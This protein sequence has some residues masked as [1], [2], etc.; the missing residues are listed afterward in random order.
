M[1]AA[2]AVTPLTMPVEGLTLAIEV[3]LLDHVPP[4]APSVKVVEAPEQ[5]VAAPDTVPAAGAGFT[6][7]EVVEKVLPQLL[8]RV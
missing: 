8:V 1:V 3:L 4:V 5:T 2:P 7:I 6:V